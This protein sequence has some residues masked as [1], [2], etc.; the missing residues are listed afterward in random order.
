MNMLVLSA[1]PTIEKSLQLTGLYTLRYTSSF[2]ATFGSSEN[3]RICDLELGILLLVVHGLVGPPLGHQHLLPC[4][5][6]GIDEGHAARAGAG[7]QH[8]RLGSD[9]LD[10]QVSSP[11]PLA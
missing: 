11:L 8:V 7:R 5:L 10:G 2:D 3:S 1:L 6:A 9:L 4:A